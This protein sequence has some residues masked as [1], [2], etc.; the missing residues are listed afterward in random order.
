MENNKRHPFIPY[1]I[2]CINLFQS[3]KIYSSAHDNICF[4]VDSNKGILSGT[5]GFVGNLLI[6]I[7]IKG[8]FS[9]HPFLTL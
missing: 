4:I 9:F 5:H 2:F 7:N 8:T 1:I 6:S 3:I